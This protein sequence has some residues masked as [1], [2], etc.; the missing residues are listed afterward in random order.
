MD[1]VEAADLVT[2]F[3]LL[4]ALFLLVLHQLS[5]LLEY[6]SSL[7]GTWHTRNVQTGAASSVFQTVSEVIRDL[8]LFTFSA[9]KLIWDGVE[10]EL[11]DRLIVLVIEF[12]DTLDSF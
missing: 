9:R 4:L 10:L 3:D 8:F 5:D 6:C 2:C 11:V 7:P 12:L 1:E